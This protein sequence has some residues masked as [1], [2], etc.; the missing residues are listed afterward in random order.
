MERTSTKK[1]PPIFK[2]SVLWNILPYYGHIH[3]W[4]RLLEKINT[5]T[6]EIWDQNRE[7]LKYVGK[8]FKKEIELDNLN[9]YARHLRPNRSWLDLFSL[10]LLNDF[11]INNF[12][13][14]TLIDNLSENEVII[15]DSH[16][17]IFKEYQIHFWR[18]DKISD[19]LPAIKCPSFKSETKTFKNSEKR[20]IIKFI[21]FQNHTKSIVIENADEKLSIN[22]IYGDTIKCGPWTIWCD[23]DQYNDFFDKLKERYKLWEIDDCACKPKKIRVWEDDF[24]S[25]KFAIYQL[26]WIS[27]INDVKLGMDNCLQGHIGTFPNYDKMVF[28]D[29]ARW[30]S[31]ESSKFVFSGDTLALVY[32]GDYYNFKLDQ[33]TKESEDSLIKGN[34]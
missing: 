30:K 17:D 31:D 6:K 5:E 7:Q 12:D 25:L 29:S 13:I 18:K 26:K 21:D 10:S 23:E 24:E 22:L 9:E 1:L 16:D 14:T 3:R 33:R 19:I 28:N 34:I 4:R 8:K 15:V 11:R 32:D 27:N 20:K 2:M